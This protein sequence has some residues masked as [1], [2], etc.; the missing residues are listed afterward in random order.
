MTTATMLL[1]ALAASGGGAVAETMKEDDVSP[2]PETGAQVRLS[3]GFSA[4]WGVFP[5]SLL[6]GTLS[7]RVGNATWSGVLEAWT[8]FPTAIEMNDIGSVNAFALGGIAGVCGQWIVSTVD[9]SACALGRGGALLIEPKMSTPSPAG[10]QP[11]AAAGGRFN[12]E[13][14]RSS[15][16]AVYLSAQL[17]VPII[18]AH[19]EGA[20]DEAG[21]PL[22][23]SWVQPWV[24]G[25]GR[26][27]F[28]L[29]FR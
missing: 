5:E 13:W 19:F 23:R 21:T 24:Y 3:G 29:R 6:G 26:I 10:W 9:M 11:T 14:P 18:R 8:V 16:L 20:R 7:L 12:I 15:L 17:F 27:G 1:L 25:G 4:E 22:E 2:F 28:L